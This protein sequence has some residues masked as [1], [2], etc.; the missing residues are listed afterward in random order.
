[1]RKLFASLLSVVLLAG[2][3]AWAQQTAS[4]TGNDSSELRQEVD[5]LKKTIAALEA[6]IAAQEQQ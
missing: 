5:N 4:T 6:R 1:M 3:A 2:P